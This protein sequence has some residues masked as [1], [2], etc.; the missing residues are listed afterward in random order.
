MKTS[1]TLHLNQGGGESTETIGG[2]AFSLLHLNHNGFNVPGFVPLAFGDLDDAEKIRT[3]LGDFLM[4]FPEIRTCAVRS[5][6]PQ[7]DGQKASFAG[8]YTTVLN[9]P[10]DVESVLKAIGTIKSDFEAKSEQIQSY[11]SSLNVPCDNRLGVL[12]QEMIECPDFAGV[13]FSRGTDNHHYMEVSYHNGLGEELVS[14]KVTGKQLKVVRGVDIGE[15]TRP[16]VPFLPDLVREVRRIEELFGHPV[17]VEFAYK[18]KELFILQARPIKGLTKESVDEVGEGEILEQIRATYLRV[19]SALNDNFLGNMIDINPQEL[20]GKYPLPLSFSLFSEMF[21]ARIIPEARA[22]LGY[23]CSRNNCLHLLGGRAFIDFKTAASNFRPEGIQEDDYRK[24]YAYYLAE[25]RRNPTKQNKVEFEL[26]FSLNNPETREKLLGIFAGD[27]DKVDRILACFQKTAQKIEDKTGCLMTGLGPVLEDYLRLIDGE[28]QQVVNLTDRREVSGAELR[29]MFVSIM[30]NIQAKGTFLF[31]QVA[32]MDFFYNRK[33]AEFLEKNGLTDRTDLLL[34]GNSSIY[35][36]FVAEML[37][38]GESSDEKDRSAKIKRLEEQF[39]HLRQ[40]QF[41]LHEPDFTE[42]QFFEK[43]LPD[44]AGLRM[45]LDENVRKRQVYDQELQSLHEQLPN[46]AFGELKLLVE[47]TRFCDEARE[48]VKFVFMKEYGLLRPVLM[49]IQRYFNL[50]SFDD[51]FYLSQEDIIKFLSD[52]PVGEG[53]VNERVIA[54][55]CREKIFRQMEMPDVIKE[56]YDVLVVQNRANEAVF[57]SSLPEVEG[58]IF[59]VP[60]A[61]SLTDFDVLKDKILLLED[62]DQGSSHLFNFGIRGVITKVGSA[63]SHMAVLLREYGL[64]AVLAVGEEMFQ[65]LKAGRKVSVNCR[66]KKVKII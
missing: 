7:E 8:Q 30:A 25:I 12:V 59:Y 11:S 16:E 45:K 4:R 63:H 19:G 62:S 41:D 29:Q 17:D 26:L 6:A 28:K 1:Q 37:A 3:K 33:L 14:G 44:L 23:D 9:V 51:I 48:R 15:E 47:R 61:S 36:E 57:I 40:S 13:V 65:K 54:N 56:D 43:N 53:S 34:S 21:P 39:G 2:K 66:D 60:K 46:D 32:R 27:E 52:E 5:S 49:K 18:N 50:E 10:A 20:L 42:Q 22:E 58:E 35:L 24:I 64:P 55:R 38:L 31:T